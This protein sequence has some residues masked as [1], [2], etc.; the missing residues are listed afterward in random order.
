MKKINFI[1]MLILLF[2][3]S[4]GCDT[5]DDAAGTKPPLTAMAT[6]YPLADITSQLGGDLV[7]VICLLPAGTSPHTYEPTI[8]QARLAS[9]AQLFIYAGAGLD[10][11]GTDLAEAA[12]RDLNL[13]D[14]SASVTFLTEG[15]S[16]PAVPEENREA[17]TSEIRP[18]NLENEETGHEHRH[19][20]INPHYWLDPVL[21][22]DQVCPRIFQELVLLLPDEE[23]YLKERYD[24]YCAE[25]TLLDAEIEE[26]VASFSSR[27][28]IAFHSAWQYFAARYNL[29]QAAV[30][31]GSPGREP[32]AGWMAALVDLIER[33][34]IKAVFAEPQFSPDL[35]DRIAEEG[36]IEVFV[37]DPLGGENIPKKDTYLSLMHYNLAVFRE[38]LN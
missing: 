37:L 4:A 12:G 7:E 6:I 32:S 8:E 20:L 18:A 35:A 29:E 34:Q 19:G 31:A 14:L 21:V 1:L 23:T 13:L 30:I 3:L 15:A 36:G 10:D 25:L 5:P 28:F 24:N 9:E 27:K 2:L 11:W 17:S 33:E 38:A 26:A 22:R 16:P